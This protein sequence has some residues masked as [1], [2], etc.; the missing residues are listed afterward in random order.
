MGGRLYTD[1]PAVEDTAAN[2]LGTSSSSSLRTVALLLSLVVVAGL[3]T[4]GL[5]AHRRKQRRRCDKEGILGRGKD[6][7]LLTGS[8]V[9]HSNGTGQ[10]VIK[11]R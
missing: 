1:N 4:W 6:S 7:H 8:P 3:G 2:S 10:S 9:A 11:R 5:V